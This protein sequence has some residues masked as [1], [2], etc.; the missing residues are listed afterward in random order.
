MVGLQGA[1]QVAHMDLKRRRRSG[2]RM[3]VPEALDERV[4]LDG[5]RCAHQQGSQQ[6]LCHWPAEQ[7]RRPSTQHP[8][9]SEH[10]ESHRRTPWAVAEFKPTFSGGCES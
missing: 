4:P 10:L 7:D 2:G 3:H 1:P 6:P 5:A 8:E 9:L